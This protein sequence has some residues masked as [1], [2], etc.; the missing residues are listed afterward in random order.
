[1]SKKTRKI[2]NQEIE[3]YMQGHVA[4][5]ADPKTG[6]VNCTFLAEDTAHHFEHDEW[7]DDAYHHVWA[8]AVDIAEIHEA[9]LAAFAG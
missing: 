8:A 1:M 4:D 9:A 6:E 2:T 5:C 7:L 3:A